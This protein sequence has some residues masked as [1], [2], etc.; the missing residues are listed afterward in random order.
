MAQKRRTGIDQI[1]QA[2]IY[3]NTQKEILAAMV[4]EVFAD[5]RDSYFNLLDDKLQNLKYN[6]AQT[7]SEYLATVAGAVPK[8]GQVL[9]ID[10]GDPLKSFTVDGIISSASSIERTSDGTLIEINFSESIAGKK[11]IPVLATKSLN[12]LDQND[13][14]A[15]FYRY[16]SSTRINVGLRQFDDPDQSIDLQIIVI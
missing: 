6:D 15:P 13:L 9:N 7:L 2:N 5:F 12:W 3:D 11:I 16:I 8:S 1:I 4:R 10:I 14:A